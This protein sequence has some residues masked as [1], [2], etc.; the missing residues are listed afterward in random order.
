MYDNVLLKL[1]MYIT[2]DVPTCKT[3]YLEKGAKLVERTDWPLT[4]WYELG[5]C[6]GAGQYMSVTR[7][8]GSISRPGRQMMHSPSRRRKAT[9]AHALAGDQMADYKGSRLL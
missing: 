8:T 3:G 5:P 7:P 4:P 9:D 6:K 2:Y 1:N